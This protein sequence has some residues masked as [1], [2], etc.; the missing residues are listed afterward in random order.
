MK[1]KEWIMSLMVIIVMLFGLVLP[2]AAQDDVNCNGLSEEDCAILIQANEAMQGYVI[3][4]LTMPSWSIDAE[5]TAGAES[6]VF[7]TNGSG[8]VVLPPAAIALLSDMPQSYDMDAIIAV[9]EMLDADL[10]VEMLEQLGLELVIDDALLDVPG[11]RMS[12]SADVIYKDMGL[13]VR[14]DAPNGDDVWF[15]EQ[16]EITDEMMTE[17]DAGLDEM[18]TGLQTAE[19]EE[20]TG[21]IDD[22]AA[23]MMPLVERVNAHVSTTRNADSE[24][25]GQNVVSFTT[26][27]DLN[28]FITD[29]ELPAAIMTFLQ[30]PALAELSGE[31][32]G[33]EINEAQIQF[34]LMAL[35]MV[36]GDT[37]FSAT[38]WIGVDDMLPHKYA[39]DMGFDLDLSL[40]GDPE[41]QRVTGRLAF[42]VEIDAINS[43][44]MDTVS[45]PTDYYSLDMLDHFLVGAAEAV[46][47][48]L[49]LGETF[50]A[51]LKG[52]DGRDVFGVTLDAGQSVKLELDTNG[53]PYLKVYGPDGFAIA[54]FDTYFDDAL[55]ITADVAGMYYVVLGASWDLDY[56]LTVRVQ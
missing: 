23:L 45:V 42:D 32:L 8:R 17:L 27:F 26:T 35:G 24:L 55:E 30:D 52:D 54:E 10:V 9:Y 18:L 5:L 4:S 49:S 12:G 37:T 46:E 38:T 51:T 31:E 3:Q 15:G 44:T 22:L 33:A 19:L 39:L 48:E 43:T 11:Q 2:V 50:S 41:M 20:M 7:K 13:Y 25:F 21:M 28:S 53:Y 29:P 1:R 47:R 16:L 56:D 6:L 14:L 40:L 36:V 34:A